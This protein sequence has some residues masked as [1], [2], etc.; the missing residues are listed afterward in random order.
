[1]R[2]VLRVFPLYFGAL[3]FV[4]GLAPLLFDW[5]DPAF[6]I[7]RAN[8]VWYWTYTVNI[9]AALTHG[10]GTPPYGGHFWSLSIEEQFYLVW[11]LI[12]WLVPARRIPLV[13]ACVMIAGLAFRSWLIWLNPV[14]NANAAYLATPGRLDGLMVGASLA[15]FSRLPGGLSRFEDLSKKILGIAVVVLC[16]LGLYRV[17]FEHANADPVM[18]VVS[19]PLIA[20]A[21]GALLVLAL[22]AGPSSRLT[23][24]LTRRSLV[25]CG[26]YSY[27]IYV[28]HLPL[29]GVALT[30]I[31]LFGPDGPL[32]AGSRTPVV[33]LLALATAVVSYAAAW[34]S[35]RFYERP[36]LELKRFFVR[37]PSPSVCL[38]CY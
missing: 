17:G 12:V 9:L 7:L 28:F 5:T 10:H 22:G 4:L 8:Q 27:G 3:V 19:Y 6:S 34:L 29:V 37:T 16:W 26:Q 25:R 15:T 23:W 33:L 18:A 20:L 36:F 30:H 38:G 1:M 35:Y 2:R 32:I 31:S 24:I 11:P 13:S 21:W 14:W